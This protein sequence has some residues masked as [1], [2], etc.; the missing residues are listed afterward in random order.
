MIALR[1]LL[2]ALALS[3]VPVGAWAALAPRSFHA[4]FPGGGR[5][6]V[7]R[8]GAY[9]EHLVTDV[10]AFY[11]A[12]ALLFAWAALRPARALVLPLACAWAL[13]STIH[14]A[15]HANHLEAF[16]T[17]DAIAQT[18]SLAIT[19]AAALAVIALARR[20]GTRA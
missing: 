9:S 7:D 18:V 1:V 2:A 17:G 8:V 13:F 4:D 11:L 6:W 12:F 16:T 14:L 15:W 19:L 5:H 3:A 10:G 20:A